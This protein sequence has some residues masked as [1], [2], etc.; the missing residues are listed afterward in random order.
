MP[1]KG[2]RAFY[3]Q[4]SKNSLSTDFFIWPYTFALYG[5]H[6]ISVTY[7]HDP[8]EIIGCAIFSYVESWRRHKEKPWKQPIE[9]PLSLMTSDVLMASKLC[10]YG[11]NAM[12]LWYQISIF[13]G[14][15]LCSYGI[16]AMFLWNQS[17][18]LMLSNQCFHGVEAVF[19]WGWSKFFNVVIL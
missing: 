10:S 5:I 7:Q 6:W 15:K 19:L 13:M 18:V 8:T 3:A 11:I 12:F 9:I 4:I 2:T 1:R 16:N 14:S 17:C